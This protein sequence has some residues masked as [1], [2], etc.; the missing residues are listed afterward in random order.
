MKRN[1]VIGLCVL[2][3]LAILFFGIE[4]LKGVN[5]FKPANYYSASYTNVAGLQVS[6]PVSVN[7]FKVGQVSNISYEY[8]NPGH[9]LVELSLDK[10]LKVPQGSKAIIEADLLGTATVHLELAANDSYHNVGD[11]LVGVT[12]SGMMESVSQDLM[13]GVNRILPTVDT[14]L[15]NVNTL[16]ADPALAASIARLDHITMSLASTLDRLDRS[17]SNLPAVMSNVYGITCNLDTMSRNLNSLSS[18][19]DNAGIDATLRNV[20]EISTQLKELS[21][22]LNS[23]DSSLGQLMHDPA[24]YQNLNGAVSSL[25]SLLIDVKKNPKRYISIKLL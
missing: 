17:V 3:A 21:V 8:D 19:L 6:A 7:G 20:Q 5:V 1:F 16:V 18:R 2:I 23:D 13:P 10:A 22:A 14:L 25:D 12:A 11:R 9:V 24:L 15:T 4:F